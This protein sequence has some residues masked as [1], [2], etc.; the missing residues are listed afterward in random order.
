MSCIK[1]YYEEHFDE[2]VTYESL[3][4]IG[5]S[6]EDIRIQWEC[7]SNKPWDEFKKGA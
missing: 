2:E 1:R 7:F 6:E 3:K 4:S 5:L